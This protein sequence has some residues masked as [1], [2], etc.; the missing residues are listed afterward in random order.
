[1]AT[2]H[3]KRKN[4]LRISSYDRVSSWLLAF[5]VITGVTVGCLV[6]VY[7]TTEW[8]HRE[9]VLPVMPVSAGGGG[10]GGTPD[11]MG[12]GDDLEQPG[13]AEVAELMEPQLQDTL[14]AVESAVSA[15]S[16]I[17][18]DETLDL[19]IEP[20]EGKGQGD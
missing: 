1:M 5:L 14:T 20:T 9:V 18:S 15:K 7:F 12:T 3:R 6:A 13:N 10:T 16:A 17:L 4:E 2:V 19:G 8:A 11:S